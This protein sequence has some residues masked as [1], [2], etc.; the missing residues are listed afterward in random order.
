M[1]LELL[2]V[3]LPVSDSLKTQ[4][5]HDGNPVIRFKADRTITWSQ[6]GRFSIVTQKR[7]NNYG[8]LNNED[9]HAEDERPLLAIVGD[10][11]VEALQVKDEDTMHGLLAKDVAGRGR[12]YSFGS[13]GSPLSTYLAYARYAADTF[14]PRAIAFIVV[15]NDFDE[16]VIKYRQEPGFHYFSDAR[17]GWPLLRV[18][19][20]PSPVRSLARRSAFVRYLALN[21]KLSWQSVDNFFAHDGGSAVESYVGNTRAEA[22]H[23][24]IADS[25]RA[26]D[27]FFEELPHQTGL[28]V[29]QV[30][31]VLDGMRPHIYDPAML[32]RARGSYFDLMRKYFIHVTEEQGYELIDMQANFQKRFAIERKRFEFPTDGHWN[33]EGHRLVAQS[34]R[35]SALSRSLFGD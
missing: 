10:S 21:L 9:Y 30:L 6:G 22:D 26:I 28:P 3:S 16:S 12:V 4:A 1:V 7:V 13:S 17:D 18:D 2:F 11:Y 24:R 20:R 5:V 35:R 31:F 27:R 33:E 8:F 29:D 34:I 32:Q 25:K 19:Y 14:R 23:A 15:G